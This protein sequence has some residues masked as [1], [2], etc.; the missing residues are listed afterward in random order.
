MN[1]PAPAVPTAPVAQAVAPGG[2]A[3]AGQQLYRGAIQGQ[4][5]QGIIQQQQAQ[6]AQQ[7]NIINQQQMQAQMAPARTV[8]VQQ[9]R[10]VMMGGGY[11]RPG[12]GMGMGGGVGVGG[13]MMAGAMMGAMMDDGGYRHH[14]GGYG[15]GWGDGGD[16]ARSTF[17]EQSTFRAIVVGSST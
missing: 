9:P 8:V 16:I 4:Q 15:R 17:C 1:A 13:A 11:V 7:Q 12:Y 14:R 10:P 2:M 6:I 5:Q 3:V